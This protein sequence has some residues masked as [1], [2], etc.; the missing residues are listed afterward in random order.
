MHFF[1]R[2]LM[3]MAVAVPVTSGHAAAPGMVLIPAGSFE[4]GDALGDGTA[5]E[6][7]VHTVTLDA[8][9]MD[10]TEVTFDLWKKVAGWAATNGYDI[11]ITSAKGQDE[12]FPA[13]S[14]TWFSA[15]KW[16]NARSEMEGLQPVYFVDDARTT[17]L[18]TGAANLH[19]GLVNWSANGYRLPTEAE[20]E[21]AAR[22]GAKGK[23]F[24]WADVDSIDH[25]RANYISRTNDAFDVSGTRGHHPGIKPPGGSPV[26]MFKPNG[27]GLHDMAG[28]MW[29][30]CWD[31]YLSEYYATSPADNPRGPEQGSGRVLRGGSWDRAGF[32]CRVSG[33][34]NATA[35]NTYTRIGF[36][37]VR[38][39]P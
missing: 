30:W 31:R 20:W 5:A 14:V 27:F 33:R 21:K 9:Y 10:Q 12:G 6:L 2:L 3:L 29:E 8:F 19:N 13:H 37:T 22:G 11:G 38:N 7:P 32:F 39:A 26:R 23:R 35:D 4:M 16:C 17:V 36:R 1:Y 28:N 34:N 18:R 15:V 25:S 24:P